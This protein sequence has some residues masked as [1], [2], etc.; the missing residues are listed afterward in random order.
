MMEETGLK[1]TQAV[2]RKVVASRSIWP[3]GVGCRKAVRVL[4]E[5]E[6]GKAGH[7]EKGMLGL[8]CGEGALTTSRLT[9]GKKKPSEKMCG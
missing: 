8:P 2:M 1:S 9:G 6:V 7:S 5:P 3:C 4:L